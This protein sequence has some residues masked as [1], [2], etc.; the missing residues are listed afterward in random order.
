MLSVLFQSSFVSFL[1]L[2]LKFI[3]YHSNKS[4]LKQ[5]LKRLVFLGCIIPNQHQLEHEINDWE[6]MLDDYKNSADIVSQVRHVQKINE[7]V[8]M[9]LSFGNLYS[10]LI[11][12]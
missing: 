4:I 11:K 9:N 8:S 12:F 7:N 2:I 10:L 6:D 1:H 5:L 3:N